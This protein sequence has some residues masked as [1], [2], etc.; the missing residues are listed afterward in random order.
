M[1]EPPIYVDLDD[2]LS[3]TARAFVGLLAR[4]LGRRVAFESIHDFEVRVH[5]RPPHVVGSSKFVSM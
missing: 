3:E 2:V 5:S 4:E 1:T